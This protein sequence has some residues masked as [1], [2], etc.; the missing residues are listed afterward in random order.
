MKMMIKDVDMRFFPLTVAS[1]DEVDAWDEDNDDDNGDGDGNDDDDDDED[2][3]DDSVGD[4][5][6]HRLHLTGVAS[7][8]FLVSS[9]PTLPS[10]SITTDYMQYMFI[11]ASDLAQS[12]DM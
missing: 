4:D 11:E 3:E 5:Q 12:S 2:E 9:L 1:S 10:L 6:R 7:C 8:T